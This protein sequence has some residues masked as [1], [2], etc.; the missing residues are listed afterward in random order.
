[1][2]C[3]QSIREKLSG[4]SQSQ[5]IIV[6]DTNTFWLYGKR[7]IQFDTYSVEDEG[8]TDDEGPVENDKISD[9]YPIHAY[10]NNYYFNVI[11]VNK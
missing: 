7:Y 11:V 3:V 4:I 10:F 9:L 8:N 5:G 6:L 2:Q 1:M